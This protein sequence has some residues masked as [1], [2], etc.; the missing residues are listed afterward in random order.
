MVQW[1]AKAADVRP[2]DASVGFALAAAFGTGGGP[3]W[4]EAI[5]DAMDLVTLLP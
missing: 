3:G 5:D 1:Q 4:R 2:L